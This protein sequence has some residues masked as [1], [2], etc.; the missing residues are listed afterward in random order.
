MSSSGELVTTKKA[1]SEPPPRP[2]GELLRDIA[3]GDRAALAQVYDRYAPTL[4]AL[5]QRFMGNRNDA[6]DLIHDLFIEVWQRADSYDP[7]RGS[8]RTWLLLRTRSRALDRL[9]SAGWRL[10]LGSSPAEDLSEAQDALPPDE[11]LLR[12]A[13]EEQ[14]RSAVLILTTEERGL[15]EMIYVKGCSLSEVA[16]QLGA[17]LGTVKS[18]LSRLLGKLRR[19]LKQPS[20]EV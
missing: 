20:S 16:G 14:V 15:V 6:E 17:P 13:T 11:E 1:A 3:S 18:R 5:A 9:R 4:L 8:V 19:S 10:L 12:R 2:D 7:R